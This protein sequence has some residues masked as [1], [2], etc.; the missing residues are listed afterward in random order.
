MLRS[1]S[2]ANSLLKSIV[3]LAD[4][5]LSEAALVSSEVV[6]S[7]CLVSVLMDACAESLCV[8]G[9]PFDGMGRVLSTLRGYGRNQHTAGG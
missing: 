6:L 8:S 7:D 1:G 9:L 2:S 4:F 3:L 5:P